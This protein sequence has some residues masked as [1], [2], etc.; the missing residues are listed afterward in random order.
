M[1][2]RGVSKQIDVRRRHVGQ[3]RVGE[4]LAE[5]DVGGQARAADCDGYGRERV[6][7]QWEGLA[8]VVGHG[9]AG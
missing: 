8:L 5:L 2:R 9:L 3:A 7:G 1:L 6:G 4:V